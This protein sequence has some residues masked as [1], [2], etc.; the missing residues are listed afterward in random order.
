MCSCGEFVFIYN[1]HSIEFEFTSDDMH[2]EAKFHTYFPCD[3]YH[4]LSS[5]QKAIVRVLVYLRANVVNV[6]AIDC[7]YVY[8]F[9]ISSI[10]KED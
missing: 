10:A 2:T 4:I 9:G 3:A 8:V 1:L 6:R 7:V 5:S